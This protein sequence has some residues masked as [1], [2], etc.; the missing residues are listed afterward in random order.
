MKFEYVKTLAHP[1]FFGE[2]DVHLYETTGAN[3]VVRCTYKDTGMFVECSEHKQKH[4]NLKQ[5]I[6]Q[7]FDK[8]VELEKDLKVPK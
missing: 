2:I 3:P 6:D 4:K 5:G 1:D 7:L 8:L